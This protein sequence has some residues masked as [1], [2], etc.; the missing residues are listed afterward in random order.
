MPYIQVRTAAKVT[1]QQE[2]A[3]KS[4]LGEKLPLMTGKHE[5]VLMVELEDSC[6]LYYKGLKEPAAAYVCV[7]LNNKPVPEEELLAFA[8]EVFLGLH[9]IL[10]IELSRINLTFQAQSLWCSDRNLTF[11][12]V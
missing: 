12:E 9:E 10:G 5:G 4:L 1:E 2:Y 7:A 11:D 3:I 8:K 6:R